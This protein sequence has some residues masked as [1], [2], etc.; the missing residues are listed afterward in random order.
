MTDSKIR[1]GVLIDREDIDFDEYADKELGMDDDFF[2]PYDAEEVIRK[3]YY[4]NETY[5]IIEFS[6]LPD[7][8]RGY[9]QYI[10]LEIPFSGE[11][12]SMDEFISHLKE[13]HD[14]HIKV[15][16]EIVKDLLKYTNRGVEITE[17]DLEPRIFS[18]L[19]Y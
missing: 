18:T 16:N 13:T 19:S 2:D 7:N 11:D 4:N 14:K 15:Y 9:D 12:L 17:K 6:L 8:M 1:Y 5:I 3:K 10:C